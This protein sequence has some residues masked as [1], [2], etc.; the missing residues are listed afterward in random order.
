M[1]R[2]VPV[3]VLWQIL[4]HVNLIRSKP[5]YA[6]P[7][8]ASTEDAAVCN[9]DSVLGP[10]FWD[11]FLPAHLGCSGQLLC[12]FSRISWVEMSRDGSEIAV[13]PGAVARTFLLADYAW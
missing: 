12:L 3:I 6:A 10:V 5:Q 2:I 11:V 13:N 1:M 7:I 4:G 8:S 9:C